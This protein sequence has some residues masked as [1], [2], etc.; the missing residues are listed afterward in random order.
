[1]FKFWKRDKISTSLSDTFIGEGTIVEGPIRSAG[2]VRLEGQLRGDLFCE[3]DAVLGETAFAIGNITA[4]NL[5]LAGQVT[6][7]V[8][9]GGKLTITATGKFY[10]DMD[11]VTLEIEE[12]GVFQGNSAMDMGEPV[13]SPVERRTGR[14]RRVAVAPD[15]NGEERRSGY[16]RRD[17]EDRAGMLKKL[18]YRAM[19]KHGQPDVAADEAAT[20]PHEADASPAVSADPLRESG[21]AFMQSMHGGGKPGAARGDGISE[22][23]RAALGM[24]GAPGL[25]AQR[26]AAGAEA[27]QP[28]NQ[29]AFGERAAEESTIDDSSADHSIDKPR[30][31]AVDATGSPD[32]STARAEVNA[33]AEIAAATSA[34]EAETEAPSENADPIEA[35]A[36]EAGSVLIHAEA[37][38]DEASIS[39]R[40]E[41]AGQSAVVD[42]IAKL[43]PAGATAREDG[44]SEVVA[45]IAATGAAESITIAPA[46]DRTAAIADDVLRTDADST[47]MSTT[48]P[49]QDDAAAERLDG[50]ADEGSYRSAIE[51][52]RPSENAPAAGWTVFEPVSAGPMK[53][54][55]ED[56]SPE[57]AARDAA[58]RR[59]EE[60]AALLRNW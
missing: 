22:N 50:E 2:N 10:G 59:D 9:I 20:G 4:R 55:R 40:E 58:S 15:W 57:A 35:S 51:D 60:A 8:R 39:A 38:F 25:A 29:T 21:R 32:L 36:I 28:A 41:S 3:G 14:D 54:N 23:E 42:D 12:G 13:V 53:R 5:F 52:A 24:P 45:A 17:R 48:I 56:A 34:A 26:P 37:S 33:A 47:P 7:N 6:G 46:H 49:P 19:E 44:E 11:A 27:A 43:A 18:S 1:M 30:S 31:A 16:D